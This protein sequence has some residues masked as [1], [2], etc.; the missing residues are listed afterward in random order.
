MKVLLIGVGTV[1]EAIATVA[2][3]RPWL[4]KMV[5][6]D[7]NLER[8]QQ[9]HD[10]LAAPATFPVEQVDAGDT[11]QMVALA[12]RHGVHLIMNAVTNTYNHSVFDAAYQ[13]GCTY[14]D[15]AMEDTGADMG[16]YQFARAGAWEQKGLLAILGIGMDPGVSDVFARFAEKHLFDEIDEIGVR[17]VAALKIS[18]FDFAPTFSILDTIEECT[19][20]A[21]VWEQ[22]KGWFTTPPFSDPEVFCFPEGIGPVECVSVEHEEVVLIPRW[23]RCRRVTFKYGLDA[24][25]MNAIRVIKLLG[26]DSPHPIDVK[27]VKVAPRDVVAACLPNPAH[28]GDRMTGKTCVGTWVKGR[29]DARPRQVYLY[30]STDNADSMKRYGCQAVAFQTGACPV[31]AMDL[32]ASGVWQGAGVL[33][34]EAFDPDPYLALMPSYGLPYGMVEMAPGTDP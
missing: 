32:L 29:K 31:I 23:I 26:L 22:D 6:A 12:R 27:G 13:A 34:A 24:Q 7:Y 16:R 10:K 2:A 14:L 1:G 15:M 3:G 11:D 30:Q 21:L 33:G 18:G 4:D 28:L 9:V 25:F 17:D 8:A 20:P 5:L 19:D